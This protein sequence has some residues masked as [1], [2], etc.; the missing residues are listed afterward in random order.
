MNL[1]TSQNNPPPKPRRAL[2]WCAVYTLLVFGLAVLFYRLLLNK[3]WVVPVFAEIV[4]IKSVWTTTSFWK[5][6]VV[7]FA[8]LTIGN[9]LAHF[10]Y[11]I[12]VIYEGMQP[13]SEEALWAYIIVAVQTVV[14]AVALLASR[15]LLRKKHG[16][17]S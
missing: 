8:G 2:L 17:S 5:G 12:P 1:A 13:W 16:V 3:M 7:R 15:C 11:V 6:L 14:A 9:A 4:L 10:F